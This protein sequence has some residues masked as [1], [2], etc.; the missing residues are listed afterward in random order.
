[1][2]QEEKKGRLDGKDS[3][4]HGGVRCGHL[5][6]E[7]GMTKSMA[8]AQTESNGRVHQCGVQCPRFQGVDSVVV[9]V[10]SRLSQGR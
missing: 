3:K 7:A 5:R 9:V 8:E 10:S 1:M 6:Y 2:A 4:E